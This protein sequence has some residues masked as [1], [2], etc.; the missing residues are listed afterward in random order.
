[1]ARYMLERAFS[2]VGPWRT[3][4]HFPVVPGKTYPQPDAPGMALPFAGVRGA[5]EDIHP[6]GTVDSC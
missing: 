2:H 5:G 4:S 1:M 6:G 3:P